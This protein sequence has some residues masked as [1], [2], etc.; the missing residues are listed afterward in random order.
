MNRADTIAEIN[1]LITAVVDIP[2]HRDSMLTL[3]NE[4][5]QTTTT[6]TL[7]TG[8]NVFWYDLRYKKIGNIVFIDGYIQNKFSI[9][10]P[11]N[12]VAVTIPDAL[13]FAKTGQDAFAL[14]FPSGT[15]T[16][17]NLKFSTNQIILG[18]AISPNQ[19]ILINAHYQT[20][21]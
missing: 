15:G 4:L 19:K 18:G 5:W 6:Q 9:V 14:G 17:V 20:A 3:V 8:S 7:T 16:N 11:K 1:G 2:E 12:T 21:D 10:K 13:Y